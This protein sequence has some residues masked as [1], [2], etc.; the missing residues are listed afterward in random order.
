VITLRNRFPR[1]QQVV[2]VFAVIC[3]LIYG[4]T[5]Y[6]T[7]QKLP[8][9]LLYLNF[10][11]IVS[12][13]AYAFLFNFAESLLV[14]IA[15]IALNMWLPKKFF[16]DTFVARCSLL[17]ILGIGY[18]IYFAIAVGQSKA[19]QFPWEIFDRAV[20]IGIALV[21][22]SILLPR[23]AIIRKVVNDLADRSIIFLYIFI[24]LTI[25][26]GFVFIWNNLF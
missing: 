10:Q 4:W 6:I 15:V 23:V 5:I 12:N 8:S 26:A 13:Y 20:Y 3:L 25:L 9:W 16:G 1:F 22:L 17:A 14:A 18:M 21:I 7:L 19:S 24:P 2:P 11:E